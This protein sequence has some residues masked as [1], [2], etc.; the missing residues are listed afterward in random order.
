MVLNGLSCLLFQGG[1]AFIPEKFRFVAEA[2]VDESHRVPAGSPGLNTQARQRGI[3]ECKFLNVTAAARDGIVDAQLLIIK[4]N[5]TQGGLRIC[6][7]IAG[8]VVLCDVGGFPLIGVIRE[9][10][11]VD[12]SAELSLDGFVGIGGCGVLFTT[13]RNDSQGYK[14]ENDFCG[15][16]ADHGNLLVE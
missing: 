12:P 10:I 3:A 6:Y 14:G 2:R 9:V 7:G 5:P 1:G 15:E 13:Q 16:D 8:C 4:Q 11:R